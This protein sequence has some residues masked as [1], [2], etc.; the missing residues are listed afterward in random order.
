MT[1]CDPP[2]DEQ[3]ATTDVFGYCYPVFDTL[4]QSVQDN[5]DTTINAILEN[6]YF[7]SA[8]ADVITTKWVMLISVLICLLVTLVYIFLM[9]Y[10]AY[11]LSWISIGLI[12][13]SLIAV[14]VATMSY[15]SD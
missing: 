10:C 4:P 13:I 14:G 12:Q 7:G 5:W 3:Y 1:T 15:R 2:V 9:H 6:S 8:L 11:W